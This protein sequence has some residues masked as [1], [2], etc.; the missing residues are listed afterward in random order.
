M[1]PTMKKTGNTFRVVINDEGQYSVV[2]SDF[3]RASGWRECGIMGTK[4]ECLDY[5]ERNWKDLV[6]R[7]VRDRCRPDA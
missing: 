3:R 2:P 4:S 1:T 6:P 7:S 5:I